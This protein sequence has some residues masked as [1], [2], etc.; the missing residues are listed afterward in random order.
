MLQG[1]EETGWLEAL[2]G[3]RLVVAAL[4]GWLGAVVHARIS[5]NEQATIDQRLAHLQGELSADSQRLQT[6]FDADLEKLRAQ[7][8]ATSQELQQE[9]DSRLHGRKLQIDI[10][11]EVL[12]AIWKA[13]VA[14]KR[15]LLA[16]TER[17][18][19]TRHSAWWSLF[20]PPDGRCRRRS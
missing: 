10:E 1:T 2:G 17:G 14:V 8:T 3:L 7:L 9:L 15:T 13:V 19:S 12:Q 5:R 18:R 11:F 16:T 4:A 6:S 20:A